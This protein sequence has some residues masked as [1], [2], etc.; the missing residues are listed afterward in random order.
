[1]VIGKTF[2]LW[3]QHGFMP[4]DVLHEAFTSIPGINRA[5]VDGC[6]DVERVLCIRDFRQD[7]LGFSKPGSSRSDIDR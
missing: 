2:D 7:P 4:I 5:F 1:M 6:G 3:P